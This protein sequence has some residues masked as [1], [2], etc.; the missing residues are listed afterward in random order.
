MIN[1]IF[2]NS[3]SLLMIINYNNK[4]QL[5][6]LNVGKMKNVGNYKARFYV[7]KQNTRLIVNNINVAVDEGTISKYSFFSWQIIF[8]TVK[9]Y[10]MRFLL[11]RFLLLENSV[12]GRSITFRR[13]P[14]VM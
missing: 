13:S 12:C 9:A 4:K 5:V 11:K 8:S 2:G 3:Y 6:H 14:Y 1:L 10:N 7:R